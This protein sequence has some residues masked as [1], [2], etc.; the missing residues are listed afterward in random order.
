MYI[1]QCNLVYRACH[2]SKEPQEE[3]GKECKCNYVHLMVIKDWEDN[4]WAYISIFSF[5]LAMPECW[6]KWGMSWSPFINN[7]PIKLLFEIKVCGACLCSVL[8]SMGVEGS[9]EFVNKIDIILGIEDWGSHSRWFLRLA[10]FSLFS[11]GSRKYSQRIWILFRS[12][13]QGG[14]IWDSFIRG[15][16]GCGSCRRAFLTWHLPNVLAGG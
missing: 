7:F 2:W 8:Q 5:Y 13:Y 16:A 4:L 11:L 9:A 12:S 6:P 3:G 1:G 10:F 15:L 14:K